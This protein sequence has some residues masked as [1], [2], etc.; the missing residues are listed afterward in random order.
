MAVSPLPRVPTIKEQC[1]NGGWRNFPE[2]KNQGEC[3]AL[4]N[5]GP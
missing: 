3:I 1:K 5:N 2:F 4:V